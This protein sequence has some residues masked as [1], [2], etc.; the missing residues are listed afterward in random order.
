MKTDTQTEDHDLPWYDSNWL[1]CYR[2]A[3]SIL[4]N[5]YPDRLA[6][7]EQAFG[8]L[9]T[10]LNFKEKLIPNFL[11]ESRLQEYRKLIKELPQTTLEKHELLTFGRLVVHDHPVFDQLQLELVDEVSKLA[12][13]QL[14]SSYNFLALYNNLGYCQPH[15]DA[16]SSKWTL[17]ICLEQSETWPICFSNI[18]PWPEDYQANTAVNAAE[19]EGWQQRILNDPSNVFTEYAMTEGEALFFSGSSQW[20]YR[21]RIKQKVK[22]NFCHL[23]FLHYIPKGTGELV[24]PNLWAKL[25]AIPEFDQIEYSEEY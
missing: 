15:M 22:Q 3:K 13:Q 9:R 20:H 2:H 21:P 16:P 25:F 18:Q 5:G 23:L 24:N 8:L 17:D 1:I 6:E 10:D 7:F 11:T 14:E 19:D 4:R 12:G